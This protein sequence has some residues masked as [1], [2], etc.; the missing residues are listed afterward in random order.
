MVY[1]LY[2]ANQSYGTYKIPYSL[3]TVNVGDKATNI[4]DYSF[5][6]CEYI[7]YINY[8]VIFVKNVKCEKGRY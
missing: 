5:A 8:D 1:L 2:D 7:Q 4:A 6:N 3:K